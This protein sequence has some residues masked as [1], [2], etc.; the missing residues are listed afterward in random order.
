MKGQKIYRVVIVQ[1]SDITWADAKFF[2]TEQGA[3][4][5]I[6]QRVSDWNSEYK[7]EKY[8]LHP[9]DFFEMNEGNY[10][11]WLSVHMIT[12]VI[13]EK[14]HIKSTYGIVEYELK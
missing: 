13:D 14:K 10:S 8:P 9:W 6:K 3:I 7:V 4:N 12:N 11:V 1:G 2:M 5:D